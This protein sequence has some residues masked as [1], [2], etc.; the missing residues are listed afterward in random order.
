MLSEKTMPTRMVRSSLR[1]LRKRVVPST[2]GAVG[3]LTVTVTL[4][5]SLPSETV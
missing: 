1:I 2:S 5:V 4:A 3:S